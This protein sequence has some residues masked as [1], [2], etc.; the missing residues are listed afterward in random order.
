[1]KSRI[2]FETAD[3]QAICYAECPVN[4]VSNMKRYDCYHQHVLAVVEGVKPKPFG[5]FRIFTHWGNFGKPDKHM[6]TFHVGRQKVGSGWQTPEKAMQWLKAR[7][8]AEVNHLA[9]AS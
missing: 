6:I 3:A 5:F 7:I 4:Y 2:D 1:M 9:F 8:K